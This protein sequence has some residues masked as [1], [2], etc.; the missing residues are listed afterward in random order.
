M[1]E[2]VIASWKRGFHKKNM[3]QAIPNYAMSCFLLQN[4]LWQE[5]E[6]II[7]N[8]LWKKQKENGVCICNSP[9]FSWVENSDLGTTN[10]TRNF[11]TSV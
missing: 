2:S 6:Q 5:M 1:C 10:P 9:F 3:L 8:F 7:H 11:M 4:V